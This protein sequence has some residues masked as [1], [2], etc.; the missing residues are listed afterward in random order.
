MTET[1]AGWDDVHRELPDALRPFLPDIEWD[2]ERLW[3]LEL[4]VEEM[5]VGELEWQLELPFWRDGERFFSVRPT[6]VLTIPNAQYAHF[7]QTMDADLAVP[8]DVTLR[9]GRWFVLDGVHRLLKA[10]AL[11]ETVVRVRKLP[12]DALVL[13]AA[14]S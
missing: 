12:P 14:T 11:G 3:R 13:I 9:A 7:E 5:S 4:P 2:R 6:D 8:I 10:F 1:A